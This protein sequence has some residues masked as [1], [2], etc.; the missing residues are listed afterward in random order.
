MSETVHYFVDMFTKEVM[1]R[2]EDT[3]KNFIVKGFHVLDHGEEFLVVDHPNPISRQEYE[4]V[5]D[6]FDNVE[7]KVSRKGVC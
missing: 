7:E 4:A 5:K 2:N 6:L 1:E 3:N